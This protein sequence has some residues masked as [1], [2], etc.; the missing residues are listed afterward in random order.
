MKKFNLL[1][2]SLV[3]CLFTA[4]NNSKPNTTEAVKSVSLKFT[5]LGR[6][7]I[8][9]IDCDKFD[10]FFPEVKEKQVID[11]KAIDSL[12]LALK[13]LQGVEQGYKPD[14]RGKIFIT[15]KDNKTDTVC[16]GVK[17]LSYKG[18]VYQTPQNLLKW[19][20]SR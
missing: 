7:T 8:M 10:S 12:M 17:M 4:C 2:I 11:K 6:E 9:S 5:E 18:T 3:V 20:Q 16:V 15:H 13:D 1:M 14:V 19:V